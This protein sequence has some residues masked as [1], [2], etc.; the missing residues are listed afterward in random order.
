M[1]RIASIWLPRWPIQRFLADERRK[2]APSVEIDPARPLVLSVDAAGGPRIAAANEAAAA[3]GL[4]IGDGLADARAKAG[5]LQERP[6][7]PAADD[8]ALRRLTLWATRYTPS[9]AP[10]DAAS[11][12]DGFFLDI[13][14]SAHLFGGEAGLLADLD[15]R[16]ARFGLEAR[17]AVADTPGAAWALSRYQ[18]APRLVLPSGEERRALASL[19]IA[20]LRLTV[21]TRQVLRRLGFKRVGALVETARAPIAARFEAEL[22]RRLDQALGAAAEPLTFIASPPIYHRTCHLLEPIAQRDVVVRVAARLMRGLVGAL[23]RDGVGARVLRLCLYRVDGMVTTVELGLAM[24][25]RSPD[26]VARLV[27]LKLERIETM[28]DAG[29]GFETLALAVEIAEP[30]PDQQAQLASGVDHHAETERFA[31]LLDR[32]KQRLGARH[33]R[34]MAPV[35]SHVPEKAEIVVA[36]RSETSVWPKRSGV[37][38]RPILLLER[39]EPAEVLA[40]IPDGPPRRF[41]WRGAIHGVALAE[42]PERIA[43]EWW[44]GPGPTRDYYLVE[45][46]GGRRFWLYREGLQGRETAEPRWFVHGLF[47]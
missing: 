38:P 6:V 22:L 34:Q 9:A 1:S 40:L 39:P 37:R 3:L 10:F 25:T 11:G 41:R 18:A 32:L 46:E 45:D 36:A 13:T 12:A 20:A 47:A 8:A 27:A 2:P 19:P 17:L 29:F 26:H 44:R 28:I 14:G 35:E 43:A 16:L 23:E 42:G 30:M 5:L 15:E 33:V 4:L 31:A 24:P 21:G 7:D